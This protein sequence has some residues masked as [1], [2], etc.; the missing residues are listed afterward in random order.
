MMRSRI[1]FCAVTLLAGSAWASAADMS[2]DE[3]V[4][5]YQEARGGADAWAAVK[6]VRMTG[7]MTMGP[8]QAPFRLEFKRE[9]RAR[10]EF[11]MQGMTIIQ[12]FDGE[13]GWSVMPMLGKTDP[14]PMSESELKDVKDMADFDGALVDY[15]KKGHKVSVGGLEEV[16]GTSAWR[17]DVVKAD[18]DQQSWWLDAEYFLPIKT[19]GK[20]ERMGQMVDV[21]TTIGDYK[22]VDGLMFPFSLAN[23]MEMGGQPMVQTITIENI[24]TGVEIGDDRFAMPAAATEG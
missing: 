4:A 10:M 14:E 23:S 6:T 20:T 11:D 2:V 13:N 19:A 5:S 24:E 17:V 3:L 1:A 9:M 18:G 22:E 15:E 7:N 12:A 16:E 8:M 21:S